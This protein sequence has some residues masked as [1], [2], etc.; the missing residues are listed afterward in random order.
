MTEAGR[1]S[2]VLESDVAL[3]YG[4]ELSC[5]GAVGQMLY[6]AG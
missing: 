3:C 1:Y 2:V 5:P 4:F 6:E